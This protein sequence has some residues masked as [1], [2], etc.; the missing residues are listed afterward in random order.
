MVERSMCFIKSDFFPQILKISNLQKSCIVKK[1]S[2]ANTHTPSPRVTNYLHLA[3]F[4]LT[5]CMYAYIIVCMHVF[6]SAKPFEHKF[7]RL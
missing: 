5:L 4:V 3:I 6:F 2:I 1:N 7:Q